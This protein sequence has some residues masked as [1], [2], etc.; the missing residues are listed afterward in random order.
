VEAYEYCQRAHQSHEPDYYAVDEV[1][2]IPRLFEDVHLDDQE[3]IGSW[4]ALAAQRPGRDNDAVRI[5]DPDALGERNIISGLRL[6]AAYGA[7]RGRYILA[8]LLEGAALSFCNDFF[9][10]SK[11]AQPFEGKKIGRSATCRM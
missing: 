3:P 2:D 4:E 10:L 6:A 11:A 9:N 5:E 7:V 1:E 8:R